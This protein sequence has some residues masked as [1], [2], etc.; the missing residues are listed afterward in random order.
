[1]IYN[2]SN[3]IYKNSHSEDFLNFSFMVATDNSNDNHSFFC[4]VKYHDN[5]M[6]FWEEKLKQQQK[7]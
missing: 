1:M 2:E 4:K 5:T 3:D 6:Q 7:K